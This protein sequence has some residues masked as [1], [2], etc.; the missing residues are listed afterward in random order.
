[1][2]TTKGDTINLYG[3]IS[4]GDGL[5]YFKNEKGKNDMYAA[6]KVQYMIANNRIF[7]T[8]HVRGGV[9]LQEILAYNDKYVLTQYVSGGAYFVYIWTRDFQPVE[10]ELSLYTLH[11][12]SKL[13]EKK[14]KPYFGDC[15]EL[16]DKMETNIENKH[17]PC[18]YGI[19][20]FHCKGK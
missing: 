5:I 7:K 12:Q 16:I 9:D 1:V 18:T 10:K 14:I 6:K 20:N 17:D 11:H 4:M 15:K 8:L 13:I 2:V 3:D 19:S